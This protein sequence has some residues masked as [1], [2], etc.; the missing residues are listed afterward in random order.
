MNFYFI[1]I[2][3]AQKKEKKIVNA[4]FDNKINL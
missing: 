1:P 4:A 2:L 3:R